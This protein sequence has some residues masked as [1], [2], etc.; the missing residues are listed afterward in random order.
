MSADKKQKMKRLITNV[1]LTLLFITVI[2]LY[3]FTSERNQNRF[4]SELPIKLSNSE[5]P[6]L[7]EK[8]VNKLLI[9]NKGSLKNITK[10]SLDLNKLESVLDSNDFVRDANL[11]VTVSGQVGVEIQQKKPIARVYTNRS[12]YI[13]E[14]GKKMPTSPNFSVRVPLV[15]GNV[16]E[17][18]LSDLFLI[19]KSINEDTFFQKQVEGIKVEGNK[20]KLLMREFDFE[21]DF[22]T[23]ENRYRK[24][25]NFKA[26]YQKALKDQTINKYS[27]VN[28]Q[29]ASQ[30]VCTKK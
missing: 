27:K 8:T 13:D 22:G 11:Y 28:L 24:L 16:S 29:I 19:L 18:K 1:K 9:Q 23:S 14:E 25:N 2:V 6:L 12:F 21:V 20:Y 15:T 30:V 26:F 7:S 17:K 5:Q 4:L 10:E 3:A